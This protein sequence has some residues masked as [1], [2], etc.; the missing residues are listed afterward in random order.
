MDTA[1]AASS[2]TTEPRP[3]ALADSKAGS[4]MTAAPVVWANG[5]DPYLSDEPDIARCKA[6]DSSLW[7]VTT[8]QNHYAPLVARVAQVRSYSYMYEAC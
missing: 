3:A 4:V 7:E 5:V 1:Q 2:F 8:L 6:M